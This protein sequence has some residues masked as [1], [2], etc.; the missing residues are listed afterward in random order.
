MGGGIISYQR[1]FAAGVDAKASTAHGMQTQSTVEIQNS[2]LPRNMI[3]K[4]IRRN[5][6]TTND[7]IEK[8]YL[9]TSNYGSYHW[10]QHIYSKMIKPKFTCHSNVPYAMGNPYRAKGNLSGFVTMHILTIY[11]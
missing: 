1:L 4:E 3:Q 6:F 7:A 10:Q 11:I 5:L 8:P 2:C 9:P